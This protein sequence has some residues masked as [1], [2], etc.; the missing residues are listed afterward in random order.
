M[1]NDAIKRIK[2]YGHYVN[3]WIADLQNACANFRLHSAD[4]RSADRGYANTR[5]NNYSARSAE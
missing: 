1:L 2:R 5:N 4:R 3:P